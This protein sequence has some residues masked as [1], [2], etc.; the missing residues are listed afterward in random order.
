MRLRFSEDQQ[1]KTYPTRTGSDCLN[2]DASNELREADFLSAA[3]SG[4]VEAENGADD[5]RLVWL[6]EVWPMLS[7]DVRDAIAMLAGQDFNNM[8]AMPHGEEVLQ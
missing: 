2:G 1:S 5:P 6:I 4:A 3:N 8:T 7:D